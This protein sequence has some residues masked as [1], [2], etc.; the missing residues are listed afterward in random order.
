E[1]RERSLGALP[2]HSPRQKHRESAHVG[3]A[4]SQGVAEA[5]PHPATARERSLGALPRP[6]VV[7]VP[8]EGPGIPHG[9]PMSSAQGVDMGPGNWSVPETV[10]GEP[11]LEK[12]LGC[13]C[14]LTCGVLRADVV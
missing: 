12:A 7:P 3:L 1:A 9:V 5:A 6:S 14:L 2:Q 11:I 4:V 10:R 8:S 13:L